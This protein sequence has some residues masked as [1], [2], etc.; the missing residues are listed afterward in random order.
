MNLKLFLKAITRYLFGV[1]LVGILLFIPAG[2]IHYWNA[3]YFMGILFI[4]MFIAGL[5]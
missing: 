3:W 2:T 4:P 5:F 1:I